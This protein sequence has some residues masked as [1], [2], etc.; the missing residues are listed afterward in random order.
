MN[1]QQHDYELIERAILFMEKN[2]LRQP[3]LKETARAAGLSEHHFQ[4]LFKR[5]AGISPKRFLQFVTSVHAKELLKG[6]ANLLD[7]AYASGLSGSGRLHDLI[8][9]T[10][11][12]TP[13]DFRRRGDAL[14]IHY[15]FHPSPFGECFIAITGRG[16]CCLEF[17]ENED[18]QTAVTDLKKQW[19]HADIIADQKATSSYIR[20]IFGTTTRGCVPLHVKGTNFQIK[21][22]EALLKI[23]DG[24]VVSYEMLAASIGKPSA[25]RAV[26]NA[27]AHN[28]IAFLI[29]CHRVIRKTG[30]VGGY[31]WGSIRKT[32]ILLW[33]AEGQ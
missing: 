2:F 24:V 29:P 7:I 4:R 3:G 31:H 33:E 12:V 15:G 17:A 6:T 26:A 11:A 13:G 5:W 16:I 32:A 8:V 21:V 1:T 28:P 19:P 14:T 9:N 30:D 27:V 23:P 18:R 25:T 22:W 20:K 10:D